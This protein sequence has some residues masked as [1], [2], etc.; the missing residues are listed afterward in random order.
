MKSNCVVVI[1]P[2]LTTNRVTLWLPPASWM[3]PAET[4]KSPLNQMYG[5]APV[6]AAMAPSAP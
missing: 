4:G 3:R 2:K 6:S 1:Y 5:Y